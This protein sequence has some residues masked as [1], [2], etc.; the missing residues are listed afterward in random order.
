MP[1]THRR[2]VE[3]RSSFQALPIQIEWA[4]ALLLGYCGFIVFHSGLEVALLASVLSLIVLNGWISSRATA[5]RYSDRFFVLDVLIAM[6]YFGCALALAS[7][8]YSVNP[9]FWLCSSLIAGFYMTWDLLV[10]P[11][12][13]GVAKK[14]LTNYAVL[15][16]VSGLLF[17]LLFILHR[18]AVLLGWTSTLVGAG[19][20]LGVLAKWY[21]DRRRR[22]SVAQSEEQ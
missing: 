10:I 13:D 2:V 9:K 20:W 12:V 1:A 3:V 17:F 4:C 7:S 22:T 14:S 18:Q 11:L 16:G 5:V 8:A 6:T 21:W 15:M 19:V